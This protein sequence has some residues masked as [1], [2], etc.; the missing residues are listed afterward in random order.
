MPVSLD[1][2]TV[3]DFEPLLSETFKFA[4]PETMLDVTLADISRVGQA[5]RDGGGFSLTFVAAHS[6]ARL[7]QGI[8]MLAHDAVGTLDIFLVPIGL[9]GAGFGY[10][11]VFT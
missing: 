7:P 11:A 8:Y 5:R 3:A 9:V 10:E 6:C 1:R 2:I 4:T